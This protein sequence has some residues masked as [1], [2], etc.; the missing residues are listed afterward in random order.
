MVKIVWKKSLL[1]I[2]IMTEISD[3]FNSRKQFSPIEFWL[4][5]KLTHLAPGVLVGTTF[6]LEL[7]NGNVK[8]LIF[9]VSLSAG[10][11]FL[12]LNMLTFAMLLYVIALINILL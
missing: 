6:S 10:N 2:S 4:Y 7:C 9:M 3:L 1:D 5:M 8:W 11:C 12:F